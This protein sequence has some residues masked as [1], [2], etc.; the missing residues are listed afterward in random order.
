M[1]DLFDPVDEINKSFEAGWEKNRGPEQTT[2]FMNLII[3]VL[4]QINIPESGRA[5]DVGCA[6]GEGVVELAKAFPGWDVDG[7]DISRVAISKAGDKHYRLSEASKRDQTLIDRISFF[8][9]SI[10]QLPDYRGW[11]YVF[12][13]NVLEHFTYP[14]LYLDKIAKVTNNY[15][16]VLTPYN[17]HPRIPGHRVTINEDT[18]P[19]ELTNKYGYKLVKRKLRVL[20][21]NQSEFWAGKQLLQIYSS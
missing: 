9:A 21:T 2:Y 4:K 15:L 5:L 20:D 1:E 8:E 17:E 12:C 19:S 14:Q 7:C 3:P 16:F 6:T 13:S 10:D 11:N 18:F